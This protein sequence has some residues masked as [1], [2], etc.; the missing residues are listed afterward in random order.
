MEVTTPS[1][2][3]T[4]DVNEYLNEG[5]DRIDMAF[6]VTPHGFTAGSHEKV[7]VAVIDCSGSMGGVKIGSAK[8]AVTT[9]IDMLPADTWFAIVT[10][11]DGAQT[12]MALCQA[13]DQNK[14]LARSAVSRI[15]ANGTTEMSAGLT[16]ALTEFRKRPGA[17]GTCI[18][19]TD[20]QNNNT[21]NP[22]LERVLQNWGRMQQSGQVFQTQCRGIGTDWKV[23]QLR[24]IADATMGGPPTPIF[25]AAHLE[26]DFKSCLQTA[27]STALSDVRVKLWIPQNVTVLEFK[28]ITPNL[29]KLDGKETVAPDGQTRIYGTGSWENES[30]EFYGALQIAPRPVG[31]RVCAG[32]IGISYRAGGQD[33]STDMQMIQ[34]QWT[35][36]QSLSA[37]I[38]GGVAKATG[39]VELAA[40]IQEG[41][42]ALE[43]GNVEMATER[44]GRAVKLAHD[45]GHEEMTER[46]R[47]IVDIVSQEE[48]TVRVKK[49]SK[50]AIMD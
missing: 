15:M 5:A 20:G 14:S 11:S 26:E 42:K 43:E 39:Q 12:L 48:G 29:L 4:L 24:T 33:V 19:L 28:Q 8:K 10:F 45:T 16:S 27:M 21:D 34:V 46:L 36:N 22:V 32:R 31:K 47:G 17:D 9:L 50:E 23:D 35:D 40:S 38:P 3:L 49:A 6:T 44:L 13:S 41:V 2:E 25:D 1:I 7:V 37:R 18:F 30:R